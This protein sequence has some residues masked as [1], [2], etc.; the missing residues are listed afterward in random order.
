MSNNHTNKQKDKKKRQAE[1][2]A[3]KRILEEMKKEIE[4]LEHLIKHVHRYNAE[5][6]FL[7]NSEIALAFI[8]KVAPYIVTAGISFSTYA[9]VGAIPFVRNDTKAYLETKKTIDS[10]GNIS[11]EEQ[12]AEYNANGEISYYGKWMP[13]EDG[14]Y[15]REV[16]T[17]NIGAVTEKTIMGVI[18]AP[19]NARLDDI[20]GEPKSTVIQT[21]NNLSEE[22]INADAYL[23]ATMYSQDDN[24]YIVVKESV[25]D[26][27][28]LTISWI[29][30]TIALELIPRHIRKKYSH[31]NFERRVMELEKEY[32]P[33]DVDELK[34]KLE[35][36][37]SNYERLTRS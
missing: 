15:S 13:K 26:N 6:A 29:V 10:R 1:R 14:L 34:R 4:R 16:K 20:F 7:K 12:Y 19:D 8:S 9:F 27:I 11:Y 5:Q 25:K 2:L 33:V 3:Q 28:L 32:K 18:D 23:E 21:R 22:E 36:K 31:F 35:I 24:E 17:Y 37:Q 30:S